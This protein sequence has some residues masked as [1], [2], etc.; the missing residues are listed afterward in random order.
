MLLVG[1]Q[2][3]SEL[4]FRRDLNQPWIRSIHNLA[5]ERLIVYVA[6]H[7]VRT[8]KLRVIENV[9]GFHAELQQLR[10]AD[11]EIALKDKIRVEHAGTGEVSPRHISDRAES[12]VFERER[13]EVLQPMT[14]G[15]GDAERFSR[16]IREV[17]IA[18]VD[19]VR[20][21]PLQGVVAVGAQSYRE[22]CASAGDAG[23]AARRPSIPFAARAGIAR[24]K[25]KRPLER[26]ITGCYNNDS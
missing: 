5:K 2:R 25:G 18:I 16:E 21:A 6:V 11:S 12:I 14:M 19:A 23:G 26:G 13:V 8:E 9:E 3:R 24:V 10:L 17:Q 4:K 15:I 7:S 20:A 22:A 1:R